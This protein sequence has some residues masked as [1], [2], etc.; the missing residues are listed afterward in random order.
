[1][2]PTAAVCDRFADLFIVARRPSYALSA[3]SIQLETTQSVY[4]IRSSRP[5]PPWAVLNLLP[6]FKTSHVSTPVSNTK[7]IVRKESGPSFNSVPPDSLLLKPDSCTTA[8][9][10]TLVLVLNLCPAR[11]TR[12]QTA[13]GGLLWLV[14]NNVFESVFGLC[15]Q[16]TKSVLHL[17]LRSEVTIR[18]HMI[19]SYARSRHSL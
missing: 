14:G 3:E 2:H 1:M 19:F 6:N 12:A 4:D 7:D 8:A 11:H 18:W 15:T 5:S 17:C 13:T 9:S 10:S 16:L